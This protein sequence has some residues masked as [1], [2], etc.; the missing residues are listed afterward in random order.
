M[1]QSPTLCGYDAKLSIFY[2]Q[3]RVMAPEF[4]Y[5]TN[6]LLWS[7]S[8]Q[9]GWVSH[10]AFQGDILG[11]SCLCKHQQ[12]A[13]PHYHSS[14]VVPLVTWQSWAPYSHSFS[15]GFGLYQLLRE[16]SAVK[17]SRDPKRAGSSIQLYTWRGHWQPKAPF[18]NAGATTFQC[19][20]FMFR[21]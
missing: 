9:C 19:H 1:K 16:I 11:D 12:L 3:P 15:S 14:E 13:E 20:G 5:Q 18:C 6:R 7:S 17:R 10:I 21:M 2:K 4:K 8:Y